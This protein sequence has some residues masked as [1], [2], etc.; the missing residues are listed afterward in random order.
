MT[1]T[2]SPSLEPAEAT[3]FALGIGP[4]TRRLVEALG[5]G[6]IIALAAVGLTILG[7][8]AWLAYRA[9]ELPYTLLFGELEPVDS[10]EVVSRLEAMGVPYRL[11]PD[12]RAIMVPG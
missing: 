3:G 9:A 2:A 6:R 12:G 10:Q 5:M 11:T 4:G 7:L 8:F 1:K